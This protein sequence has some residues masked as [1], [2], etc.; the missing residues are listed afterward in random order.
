MQI[1]GVEGRN[2][3]RNRDRYREK[4]ISEAESIFFFLLLFF[5]FFSPFR[6]SSLQGTKSDQ[7]G[8]TR[9]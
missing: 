8:G 7:D 6:F 9:R 3:A 5:F 2:D 4:T 1:A